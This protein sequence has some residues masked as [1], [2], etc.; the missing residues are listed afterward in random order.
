MGI[1]SV[2]YLASLNDTCVE[3]CVVKAVRSF[4]T[5]SVFSAGAKQF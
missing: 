2:Q 3:S 5:A 1:L 4:N